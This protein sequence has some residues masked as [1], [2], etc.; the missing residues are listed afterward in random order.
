[1]VALYWLWIALLKVLWLYQSQALLLVRHEAQKPNEHEQALNEWCARTEQTARRTR[2]LTALT[3]SSETDSAFELLAAVEFVR[4][5]AQTT[6]QQK[7]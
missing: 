3:H 1:M 7:Q 6:E 4:A 2:T 5:Q